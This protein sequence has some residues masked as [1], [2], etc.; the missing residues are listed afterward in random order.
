MDGHR[1]QPRWITSMKQSSND[2][3]KMKPPTE[4]RSCSG[5]LSDARR[6]RIGIEFDGLG[7]ILF[8]SDSVVQPFQPW[9]IAR[10]L[11]RTPIGRYVGGASSEKSIGQVDSGS[12]L[13]GTW[14]SNGEQ[15][16]QISMQ[17]VLHN[18]I[19]F[20]RRLSQSTQR[21]PPG[22]RH[23]GPPETYTTRSKPLRRHVP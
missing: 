12:R 9:P 10:Y 4:G 8:E 1:V 5:P 22:T 7:R 21:Q 17:H 16:A 2:F 23:D 14:H 3:S 19:V 20:A 15:C 11:G 18:G 6:D 13:R